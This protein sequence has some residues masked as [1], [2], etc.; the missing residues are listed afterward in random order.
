MSISL[1]NTLSFCGSLQ[2]FCYIIKLYIH[3]NQCNSR[4]Q[5]RKNADHSIPLRFKQTNK[6]IS[7]QIVP[8]K[9]LP[10]WSGTLQTPVAGDESF[11]L[12]NFPPQKSRFDTQ[13]YLDV[14]WLFCRSKSFLPKHTDI[15]SQTIKALLWIQHCNRLPSTPCWEPSASVLKI[16][17]MANTQLVG[18]VACW[19]IYLN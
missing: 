9:L 16:K 1:L 13:P 19:R 3:Y 5:N 18:E 15:L 8:F 17:Y 6:K 7:K 11:S 10:K 2:R 14:F 12:P 4:K